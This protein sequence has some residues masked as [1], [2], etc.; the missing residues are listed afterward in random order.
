MQGINH[1]PPILLYPTLVA[2]ATHFTFSN[3]FASLDGGCLNLKEQTIE[4]LTW[5]HGYTDSVSK[6][7]LV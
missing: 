6:D 3:I 4:L 7:E 1:F 2:I 5:L